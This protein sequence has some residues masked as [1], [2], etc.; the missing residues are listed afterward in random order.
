MDRHQIAF[1]SDDGKESGARGTILIFELTKERKGFGHNAGALGER[2][3]APRLPIE[4]KNL[5]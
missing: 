2:R 5:M 4:G 1:M 3:A